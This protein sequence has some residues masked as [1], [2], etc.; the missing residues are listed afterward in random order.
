MTDKQINRWL[1]RRFSPTGWVLL[2]Y[3][4]LINGLSLIAMLWEALY[5]VMKM[6]HRGPFWFQQLDMDSISANA[7]GYIVAMAVIFLILHAWKG[8]DYW[9]YEVFRKEKTM[10]AGTFFAL[11]CLCVGSQM[12][13]SF[14]VSGLELLF[15]LF[16]KSLMPMLETVS[17]E[18]DTVSTFLYAAILA[19]VAEG[20]LFRGYILRTLQPYGK[21]FAIFGSAFFTALNDGLTSALISF[22]RTMVFQVAAVLLLP[23]IWDIDGVWISIVVAEVMAAVMTVLFLVLKRKKYE[24]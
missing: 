14:W 16:D 10:T 12:V 3:Y 22:L 8:P 24:Y 15:R 13:N 18:S 4:A 11:L 1:R 23:L 7:W 2:A 17:G 9:R 5:Q 19:P 20:L 6:D 21:K